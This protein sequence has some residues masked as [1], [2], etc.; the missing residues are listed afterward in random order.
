MPE[1]RIGTA[2]WSIPT[3]L[4]NHFPSD[5]TSL[6]RYATAFHCAEINST[7][8]RSHRLSTY[9]RW[10]QSTPPGFRFSA[11]LPKTITHAQKLADCEKLLTAYLE[12]VEALGERLAVHLVQLPP[13][14]AFDE[15]LATHFFDALRSRTTLNIACEPRHPSWFGSAAEDLFVSR[16]VARVAADPARVE[17]AAQSGGWRGLVYYRLHGTPAMYRSSYADGRLE[18]YAERLRLAS[19]QADLWCIFDNTASSAA[20]GDALFLKQ[21]LE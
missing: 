6:E 10:A 14:L 20:T 19:A 2:G 5:G 11:K 7:F 3:P 4:A 18:L 1:L 15:K 12:E 21:L 8:H 13:S 9:E 17:E 16:Q